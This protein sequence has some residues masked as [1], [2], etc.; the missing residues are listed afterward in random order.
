MRKATSESC[1]I[2]LSAS[3]DIQARAYRFVQA[4]PRRLSG[5]GFRSLEPASGGDGD[6]GVL[7]EVLVRRA[8]VATR[9]RRALAGLSLPRRRVAMRDSA[10]EEAGLDLLLDERGRGADALTHRPGNLRLSGDR[11]VAADVGE[12][13]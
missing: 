9:E 2:S 6:R 13:G 1:R 12:Q 3:C 5:A 11:E 7:L 8:V 4:P 10:V